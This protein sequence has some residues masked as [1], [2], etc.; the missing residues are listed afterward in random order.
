[1]SAKDD[2]AVEEP[3]E[4]EEGA[5]QEDADPEI[6]EMKRKVQEMEEE[7][8]KLKEMQQEVEKQM[9]SGGAASANAT[10]DTSIYVGQV[11]VHALRRATITYSLGHSPP[12]LPSL[13]SITKRPPRNCRPT[14]RRVAPLIVLQSCVI[15]SRANRRATRTSRCASEPARNAE[16]FMNSLPPGAP[17]QREGVDRERRLAR[18]LTLQ[19]A[20]AQGHAETGEPPE[21]QGRRQRTQRQGWPIPWWGAPWRPTR[22]QLQLLLLG[23][24]QRPGVW[25]PPGISVY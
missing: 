7:A 20:P 17:V 3:G 1:M 6:E 15:N 22:P 21:L 5:P 14:S 11:G 12:P 9:A 2:E 16:H 8:A 4:D 23:P 25:R 18:Q 13:R 10:D 24:K 19:R